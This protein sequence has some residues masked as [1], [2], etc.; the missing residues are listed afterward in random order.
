MRLA[1]VITALRR[2]YGRQAAPPVTRP[3]E[4]VLYE[5]ASYLVDDERRE[6]VW[7]ALRDEV[8]VTPEE[9]LR[10]PASRLARV[11]KDGGMLP[12]MR[13]EKLR[14]AARIACERFGGDLDAFIARA[15]DGQV[16]IVEAR[17]GLKRFPGFGDPGADKALLFARVQRTLGLDS[18]GLRAIVRLGFCTEGRSYAATYRSAREAVEPEIARRSFDWLIA[19]HQLLRRHGQALC[20]NRAP[21][22]DRCPLVRLC[23]FGAARIDSEGL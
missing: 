18:N 12:P 15:R 19:V 1:E 23:P 2:A 7:R 16:S 8:G 5:N 10:C 17:R 21:L 3:F 22:C 4:L 13:A 9:I 6:R 11:I 14:K 20:R